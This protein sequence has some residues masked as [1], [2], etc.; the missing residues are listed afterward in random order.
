MT[1]ED[2]GLRPAI[3]SAVTACG[4]TTPTPIQ[5]QAIPLVMAGHDLIATAQTGTG[6]TAAFVLPSLE[7]LAVRSTL[8]GN[9]PRVLVLTPT[10]ELASQVMEAA[11]SYGKGMKL[12]CGSIVGG[13]PYR[14]QFRLLAAP[15][16]ILVATPGRLVDH[17]A[18]GS[19]NFN[20]LELLILDEA[21]RM[22]DMGFSDDVDAVV[23]AAPKERQTLLF[24]ATMDA[25]L[26]RLAQRMLKTPQ[27]I[28]L[29]SN[30]P[31]Q[32]LIEQRL[33]V[34]DNLSHKKELLRNLISDGELT[35]AI[36]FSATKKDADELARE[37]HDEGHAVAALHGD[38]NQ[39]ARNKTIARMKG[40]RLRLL[41]A[42][43]VAARGLD[44]TGIS[45]V[46]NFDLPRFAEDYVHRIGRTGRAGVNG[47][48]ISFVSASERAYLD[49][50]ER[51][52]GSKV[53][54]HTIP[55]LEP[56]TSLHR[57]AS[58]D[59]Y[60]RKGASAGGRK[61]FPSRN[62][63]SGASARPQEKS[64]RSR[65]ERHIRSGA[66]RPVVVEYRTRRPQ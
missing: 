38:M 57:P 32:E 3:L 17:M 28:E 55:G 61:G 22:L 52:I 14:D 59:G 39:N 50:I 46:I 10:R 25:T 30:Q 47:V 13:M 63:S 5:K 66:S 35:K 64:W 21:D 45:H 34:T 12:R 60:G 8:P 1:F 36:I 44:V 31:A 11:R 2:L 4:Y 56:M 16:D 49:K 27:R 6:K 48:A 15:L 65:D 29:S 37:L 62:S 42:T 58:R 9:G 19:V 43:D 51:F 26:A 54:V 7:R 41:V 24:T 33:H 18:R 23:A 20:R 53:P 40:G